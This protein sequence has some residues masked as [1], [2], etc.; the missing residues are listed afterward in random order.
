MRF[1]VALLLASAV[2]SAAAAERT[3]PN[4]SEVLTIW[5]GNRLD[6][7]MLKG[8][9]GYPTGGFVRYIELM[10]ATGGSEERDDFDGT[11][12]VKMCRGVVDAGF[13]PYLK[14]GNV[15]PRFSTDATNG[16][17]RVNIRPPD[18]YLA[19]YRYLRNL[20]EKL[21]LE[22]GREEVLGWRFSVLTEADNPRWFQAAGGRDEDTRREFFRL[23]DH[24]VKAME[25]ELGE[26]LTIGTHLINPRYHRHSFTW[27]DVVEH[28]ASGTNA[29]TGGIGAPLR[30]LSFSYYIGGPDNLNDCE[31]RLDVLGEVRRELDRRGFAGTLIGVDEGRIYGSTPGM[32]SNALHYRTVGQSFGAAFDVRVAKAMF[33]AGADYFA[34]WGFFSLGRDEALPSHSYFALRE[35]AAF[36]GMTAVPVA[37]SDTGLD[38]FAAVSPRRD[39]ARVMVGLVYPALDSTNRFTGSVSVKLPKEFLGREAEVETLTLDDRNNW[40]LDA[41]ADRRREGRSPT[42]FRWSWDCPSTVRPRPGYAAKAAAV[43]PV[44]SRLSVPA[45]GRLELP[46]AFE[47]S[48]AVFFRLRVQ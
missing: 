6:A 32:V 10:T 44:R 38:A 48:T 30:I 34:E 7:Q 13:K 5:D 8:S 4:L 21:R 39:E 12:L 42:E 46:L 25:D 22:F 2:V 26:G 14:L 20:A 36:R 1:A 16:G 28:C 37:A 3:L 45:V 31:E 17:F 27:R 47:G 18:D 33:D 9:D 43:R 19:Y 15:P 35:I 40:F 29:A 24:S 11:K 41:M 23:Y